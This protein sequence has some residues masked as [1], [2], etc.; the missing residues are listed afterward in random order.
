M[1]SIQYATLFFT[2]SIIYCY[3]Y[4]DMVWKEPSDFTS[5]CNKSSNLTVLVLFNQPSPFNDNVIL[6]IFHQCVIYLQELTIVQPKKLSCHFK[7]L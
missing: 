6:L 3:K 2:K 5:H 7:P 1:L 4:A